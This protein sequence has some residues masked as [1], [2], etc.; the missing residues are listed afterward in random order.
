MGV[1]G[2]L[3]P[4]PLRPWPPPALVRT[5]SAGA[6]DSPY[7]LSRYTLFHCGRIKLSIRRNSRNGGIGGGP[8]PDHTTPCGELTCYA[9]LLLRRV[10][11]GETCSI[12]KRPRKIEALFPPLPLRR[13]STGARST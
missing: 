5:R 7:E 1:W 2:A 11:S 13:A 3:P 12:G 8:I 9:R 10:I 4:R 6:R